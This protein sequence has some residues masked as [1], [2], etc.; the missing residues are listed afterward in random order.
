MDSRNLNII[1]L[2][3]WAAIALFLTGAL[4]YGITS[5][6]LTVQRGVTLQKQETLD[7]S[8]LDS[9]IMDFSSENIVVETT[10]TNEIRIVESASRNLRTSEKFTAVREGNTLTIKQGTKRT[11]FNI[12]SFGDIQRK[13]EITIPEN[14]AGNIATSL[15]SG[16]VNMD[17][18]FAF[19]TMKSDI[20]SGNF[21]A[22]GSI[23]ANEATITST[24]GNTNIEKLDAG[25]YKIKATSGD[26]RLGFLS[27]SGDIDGTSG[28]ITISYGDIAGYSKVKTTSGNITLTVPKDLSFEFEGYAS[29]GNIN[30]DFAMTYGNDKKHASAQVGTEPYKK[31][32]A[33]VSSGNININRQ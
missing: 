28:N 31:L 19:S 12:F 21:T 20:T 23:R 9:I 3:L 13:I 7:A 29:S 15:S 1:S 2:I 27:G 5:G 24:S 14:Y 25:T 32:T 8:G 16:N 17:G 33:E 6:G 4:I 26:M 10:T 18:K 11:F 30:G 22:E